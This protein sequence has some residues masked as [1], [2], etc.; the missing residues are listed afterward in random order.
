MTIRHHFRCLMLLMLFF[1]SGSMVAQEKQYMFHLTF[2]LQSAVVDTALFDNAEQL[3][4]L[5]AALAQIA[6]DKEHQVTRV[7][8][9]GTSSPDGSYLVNERYARLRAKILM[10]KVKSA[11]NVPDSI[12]E[13]DDEYIAWKEL[14]PIIE[15][16]NLRMKNKVLQIINREGKI[17][18]VTKWYHTDQ[19]VLDLMKLDYGWLWE[20]MKKKYF[21]TLRTAQV[22][23]I[24]D[25]PVQVQEEE[26]QVQV[27]VQE[28]EQPATP[29]PVIVEKPVEVQE[30]VQVQEEKVQ[31][32]EP[33]QVQEE[34]VQVQEQPATPAPVVVEKP[35]QVQEPIQVQEEKVQVQEPVQVQEE[36]VQVQVQ[37]Q[38]LTEEE[39]LR[40][41]VE[42]L[43][44]Q[45]AQQQA[46]IKR[47]QEEIARLQK[48][49][50]D[51]EA[52]V[53]R[54][55]AEVERLRATEPRTAEEEALLRQ[56]E[57]DLAKAKKQM[58]AKDKL[59]RSSYISQ[60][61]APKFSFKS[62]AIGWGL[63]MVNGAVEVDLCEH[64][65]LNVPVYWS[66]WD[67]FVPTIKFRT[68]MIQPELRY[69][70]KSNHLGWFLGAHFGMAYYN[71]AI[72]GLYRIQDHDG[73]SPA[74]GGGLAFGYRLPLSEDGN[75]RVEFSLG[76]GAYAVNY[77]K[78]HNMQD[79]LMVENKKTVYIGPDQA[80]ITFIY[81]L[82]L[83]KG[84]EL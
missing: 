76:V 34:K 11:L 28:Q 70:F 22:V 29:A 79:G 41:E 60:G 6:A 83:K 4:A 25:E 77:D 57:A 43:N 32:Q 67:Y 3:E 65:S 9:R 61:Y 13:I 21:E 75:W 49:V 39:R 69:Y 8:L 64:L 10:L 46:E 63:G 59:V 2:P 18:H 78:F 42:R 52:E 66:A 5:D 47:Q 37:E 71:T 20:D 23:I 72:N 30:P 50:Q 58:E 45:V 55:T 38:P 12:I 35:V 36:K 27:Q 1:I 19:R 56:A 81:A 53:A 14:V 24:T 31:V 74:L 80:S 84:G 17:V 15:G 33:V 16:S 51:L 40:S 68:F 48:E 26:V 82:D 54:L 62:N 7:L 73:K 44:E